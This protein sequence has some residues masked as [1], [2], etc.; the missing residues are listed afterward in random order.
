MSNVIEIQE[1]I[2]NEI[3][4]PQ[5]KI[6]YNV[7][8]RK[9]DKTTF[10][11]NTYMR[12][13]KEGLSDDEAKDIVYLVNKA[14]WGFGILD[15]LVLNPDISDIRLIDKDNIRIKKLGQRMGT[16]IKFISD[17]EYIRYI[18]FITNR[19][20]TN[21][22]LT[23]ANQ[24]FT[25]K[26]TCPTDILRFTL[27]SDMINSNGMPTLL[28]RK[29]SKVKKDFKALCT[30]RENNF[31][32]PEEAEY[33]KQRWKTGHS[34]LVCGATGAGKTTLI[35]ALL[36]ETPE[37]KAVIV[38]QE[39]EELFCNTHP[40]MIFRKIIPKKN[41]SLINYQLKDIARTALV[42]SF[43]TF[44][45][46]EVKGD[47]AAELSYAVY[48]GSQA[49]TSVHSESAIDGYNKLI[50]YALDAQP[51]RTR[52]HFAKQFKSIDTVVFIKD[53]KIAE[54][55][56]QYGWNKTTEEFITKRITFSE[57]A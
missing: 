25:D 19:N 40:E 42:E 54:I 22:S 57:V 23:N 1:Q 55:I 31:C 9:L 45:V 18:E 43:D 17:E 36:E 46:G 52:E 16:G 5:T 6:M 48:N 44:V 47:E 24:I 15:D 37:N 33:L 41:G 51:N 10:L 30:E 12:C 53:Y 8:K 38:L 26:D 39:S 7:Q 13:K 27:V 29:I 28:I 50:D 21:M 20:N 35:N 49:M 32:T 2:F 56:E 4:D 34:I 14:L 11:N 3:N